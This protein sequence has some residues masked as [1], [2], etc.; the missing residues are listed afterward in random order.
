MIYGYAAQASLWPGEQLTLH[1][2]CGAGRFRVAF[3]RWTGA[4]TH[5]FTTPWKTGERAGARSAAEDWEWPRYGIDLPG[6]WPTGVYLAHLQERGAPDVHIAMHD[7]AVLFVVRGQ[8]ASR[9]L[10][11]IPLSTYNAY[12]HA[13]GGCFYDRPPRSLDPPGAR[14]SFMRPGIGIGGPVFGAPDFYDPASPRQTFAHWD[15][16]FIGWLLARGYAP[17]FCT[18]L[19]IHRD[20]GLLMGYRLLL[21]VGHDEYWSESIRDAVE[22]FSRAG[23]NLAFFSANV[24]WWRIHL[25]DRETA[26]VCHQGG[27]IGALDHWWPCSGAARPEDAMTG[28]SYRHGGGWWDGPRDS[29]GYAVQEPNHWIFAG[30]GLQ[31]GQRFGA[32]TFPPLVG[33]ECD[34]APIASFDE[35]GGIA[36]LSPAAP[37]CGTPGHYRLLAACPLGDRWQERP[38]RE[39]HASANGIHAATM[40]IVE[41]A[42]SRAMANAEPAG[43]AAMENVDPNENGA[44]DDT[45]PSQNGVAGHAQLAATCDRPDCHSTRD[46]C[47]TF[48]DSSP[49]GRLLATPQ[50]KRRGQRTGSI[51]TAGTTDWAQV[52]ASG[53]D[54]HVDTITRNVLERLLSERSQH[55]PD[56]D[57]AT[58]LVSARE[59]GA[60]ELNE[61]AAA[62]APAVG[63][64]HGM[65][66]DIV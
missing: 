5:M 22:G 12:N 25:V 64:N 14:L 56:E 48:S 1:V 3:Y 53:Q 11:K 27:P 21:S 8:S 37:D 59:A 46:L 17:E 51:F 41:P 65:H 2:S 6:D 24:C 18:D 10:Y 35:A 7:A 44:R 47:S 26:M 20:P 63:P 15:A 58:R 19:D 40:G 61:H 54:R 52:L 30:T 28:S 49:S 9:L 39:A 42:A 13:G 29:K 23:G 66:P 57:L 50:Y 34:G 43:N 38:V 32:G 62:A 31:R 4:L 36:S 55:A 33:Y 45:P 60:A 16:P